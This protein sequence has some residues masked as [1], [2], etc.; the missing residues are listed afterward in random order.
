[1][2][3]LAEGET[4]AENKINSL[5]NQVTSINIVA[6]LGKEERISYRMDSPSAVVTLETGSETI[7]IRVG[8]QDA[9]TSNY[10][11]KASS[12]SHYVTVAEYSVSQLVGTTRED[13]LELPPTPTPGEDTTTE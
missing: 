2:G 8:A 10:F 6:P 9:E 12:E 3:G 1:M 5:L 11:I 4:L 13:F 7:T